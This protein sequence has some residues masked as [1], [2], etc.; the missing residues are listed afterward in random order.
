MLSRTKLVPALFEILTSVWPLEKNGCE[1]LREPRSTRDACRRFSVLTL[2][3]PCRP[4]ALMGPLEH[5]VLH[6]YW[7]RRRIP[8]YSGTG[9]SF[10][11]ATVSPEFR[12]QG[13]L[14][15]KKLHNR[16]NMATISAAMAFLAP[17]SP[18][19]H[20]ITR[21]NP[22]PRQHSTPPR[23]RRLV[24]ASRRRKR[25]HRR[26]SSRDRCSVGSG[27]W[28]RFLR[29]WAPLRP[30]IPTAVGTARDDV[31]VERFPLVERAVEV[32]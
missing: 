1:G 7:I 20:P 19:G 24:R 23:P 22:S 32:N 14:R 27:V 8:R 26:R 12:F 6:Q 3:H 13:V 28:L 9:A 25:R 2:S 16:G 29:R 10:A 15:V 18:S 17:S 4:T 11:R 5:K 31:S 21:S 30:P